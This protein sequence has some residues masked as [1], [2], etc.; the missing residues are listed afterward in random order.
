MKFPSGEAVPFG[1]NM[2]R[3]PVDIALD[4]DQGQ[5]RIRNSLLDQCVIVTEACRGSAGAYSHPV[6]VKLDMYPAPAGGICWGNAR[7]GIVGDHR[8]IE[9]VP[10]AI[11]PLTIWECC[12]AVYRVI[13]CTTIL[14]APA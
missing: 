9:Q 4:I 5:R 14:I 13:F 11:T 7:G 1:R 2:S 3:V 8:G 10:G 12:A 6:T